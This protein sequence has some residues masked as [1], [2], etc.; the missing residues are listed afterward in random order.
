[1]DKI[2]YFRECIQTLLTHYAKDDISSDEVEVQL[3]FDT[4]RA[5]YQWMNVGW[6][7]F[8]RI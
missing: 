3:I 7:Q 4:Q 6:Q 5:H 8:E 1:M 2:A